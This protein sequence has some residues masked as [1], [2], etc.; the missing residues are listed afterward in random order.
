MIKKI[1]EK[2]N[3]SPALEHHTI[4]TYGSIEVWL[5]AFLTSALDGGKWSPS[6]PGR[7]ISTKQPPDAPWI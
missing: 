3:L 6:R 5:H 1:Y 2:L 7:F 4:K